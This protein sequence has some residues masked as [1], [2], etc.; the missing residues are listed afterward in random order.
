VVLAD[1]VVERLRA[2]PYGQRLAGR[3]ALLRGVVEQVGVSRHGPDRN[4]EPVLSRLAHFCVA[5]RRLVALTWLL[6]F[7][8]GLTLGAQVFSRLGVEYEGSKIE[9]YRG[10]ELLSDTAEYGPR[11]LALLQTDRPLDADRPAVSHLTAQLADVQAIDGVGRVVNPLAAPAELGLTTADRRAALVPVDIE[12]DLPEAQEDHVVDTATAALRDLAAPGVEVTIGGDR[13][14][15]EE[16]AEQSQKDTELG[17]FVALPITLIVMV[18][19]FGGLVAAGVPFLGAL[20]SISG[21]LA[22][23]FGMSYLF[24]LDPAVPSVTTVMGLG[25]SIDYSL[26]IVSRYRE[27]RGLG[28]SVEDA[29]VVTMTTAGRTITFSAVTVAVSL[30]GLF[31]FNEP[32]FRG[33]ASAGVTVVVIA[34]LV[35]LTLVPALLALFARHISA[36]VT[37][38]SDDGF[39]ARLARATQRRAV[40]VALILG[41]LLLAAG[42]PFLS[43]NFRNGDA[44]LLP[45]SLESRQFAD[46]TAE[47]FP[48][49][50]A[51]SPVV[52]LAHVPAE[53]LQAYVESVADLPVVKRV[54]EVE[55][56]SDGWSS[57][58]LTPYG[59]SQ[60]DRAKDLVHALRDQRPEFRTWVTGSAAI[61]LDFQGVVK[62]GLPWAALILGVGTFVLLF[63]MTGSVLVPIKALVMNTL[64]L[65]ATFGV[66]VLVFQEGYGSDLLGFEPTGGLETWVPVIVFAFAFGL[67]MDYEVF[68][69]S[70]VK[71]LYDSG[72]SN[73]RAVEIGLQRSGR[74]ITSAALLVIIV[75]FGFAAGKLLGIKQLGVALATAVA[76]DAT[77]VRCLL[78]PATM[79]LLGDKNWWAPAWLRRVHDRIG[80]QEH[81]EPPPFTAAAHGGSSRATTQP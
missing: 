55:Q 43:A 54:G 26:L 57:V 78:V 51:T 64:S 46:R 59:E 42:A 37:R 68:L 9:S 2:H 77:L 35:A 7:V 52:V 29:I 79:T 62:D 73:D 23:L 76:V 24:E 12:K 4:N 67:S 25:L 15:Q 20:A 63:L 3:T 45:T 6:V 65:G 19:L 72:M 34:L 10:Q 11:V 50:E 14:L 30:V 16:L 75:F 80:L 48:E 71:E 21:G 61:L 58:E 22:A 31:V 27:E 81:V 41:T 36:P 49:T 17:E 13:L 47:L 39:F 28:R 32:V 38:V 66:L 44:D 1:D 60:G 5:R 70:R 40:P 18:F 33:L 8:G 69:L 56:R 53:R 74:I